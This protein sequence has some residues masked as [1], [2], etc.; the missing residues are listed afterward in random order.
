MAYRIDYD[1]A[2]SKRFPT[3]KRKKVP[4]W[5]PVLMAL[6]ILTAAFWKSIYPLLLP[7]DPDVTAWAISGF[8]QDIKEGDSFYQAAQTFCKTVLEGADGS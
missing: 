1:S 7:G 8:T 2:R 4:L 5:L 3:E 6:V